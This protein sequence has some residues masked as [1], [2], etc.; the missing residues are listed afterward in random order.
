MKTPP[1]VFCMFADSHPPLVSALCK[2]GLCCYALLGKKI[3]YLQECVYGIV[4]FV[5]TTYTKSTFIRNIHNRA[6]TCFEFQLE[7]TMT[8]GTMQRKRNDDA[9]LC[10]LFS[11][12][13]VANICQRIV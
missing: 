2:F 6:S 9:F 5:P 7:R 12:T 3:T 8:Y 11:A 13:F 1:K 10:P 4:R